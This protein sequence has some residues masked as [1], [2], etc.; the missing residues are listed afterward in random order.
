MN[1]ALA[2]A[3]KEP[4]RAGDGERSAGKRAYNSV[5][6]GAAL[7]R[8]AFPLG[9][10]GAGTVCLEGTGALS[11][12]SI[13]NY[14]DVFNEPGFF[15]AL[16][17]KTPARVARDVADEREEH[18]GARQNTCRTGDLERTIEGGPAGP[19]VAPCTFG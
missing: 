12:F 4:T 5:W 14:P 16:S 1:W 19:A 13:Q 2:G 15:A 10:I 3:T 7:S 11:H 17:V 9:G 8:V 18:S 6:E